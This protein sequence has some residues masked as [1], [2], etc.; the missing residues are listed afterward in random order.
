MKTVEAYLEE[1]LASDPR[2][3][4]VLAFHAKSLY[5]FD[6]APAS[7]HNHQFWDGGYRIHLNQCFIVAE[8]L[9]HNLQVLYGNPAFSFSSAIVVLYFH[10][11]E[12]IWKYTNS[13]P[14]DFDKGFYYHNSLRTN[15][16]ISFT[17][18]ESNALMY[19]HGESDDYSA[20]QRVMNELAGFC[21]A[22]D[23]ISARVLH[24]KG[25]P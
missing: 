23:V 20:D 21:H 16:R 17:D 15:H 25:V 4:S 5:W 1:G 22:V 10:D 13:L 18:Q 6:L 14:K 24:S 2:R 8:M 3:A 11:I 19:V 12:K 9:Y 7:S